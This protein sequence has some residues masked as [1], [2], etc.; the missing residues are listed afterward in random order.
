MLSDPIPARVGKDGRARVPTLAR[1]LS[2]ARIMSR[3]S[4]PCR[5]LP[6]RRPPIGVSSDGGNQAKV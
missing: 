1:D 6:M 3:P 2:R 4:D 5:A